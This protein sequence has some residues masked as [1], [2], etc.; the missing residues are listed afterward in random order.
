MMFK[1][2]IGFYKS[3][4]NGRKIFS[5][6]CS[7]MLSL[8]STGSLLFCKTDS[9]IRLSSPPEEIP[10]LNLKQLIKESQPS[11]SRSQIKNGP[12]TTSSHIPS[13]SRLSQKN[14]LQKVTQNNFSSVLASGRV[15]CGFSGT[16]RSTETILR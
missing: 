2:I 3:E 12:S 7:G 5:N 4:D 11:T 1:I 8:Q 16:Y 13:S 6:D 9:V 10:I 14:I 15:G